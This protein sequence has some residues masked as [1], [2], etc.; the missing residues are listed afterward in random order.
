MT[1]LRLYVT[2]LWNSMRNA[3]DVRA[4]IPWA[5]PISSV[6]TVREWFRS[7]PT[8]DH[9]GFGPLAVC[10]CGSDLFLII[11]SFNEEGAIATYMTAGRCVMCNADVTVITEIDVE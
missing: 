1:G 6:L 4:P 8:D 7:Q 10:P 11:A 9:T 3:R 2:R 5:Y